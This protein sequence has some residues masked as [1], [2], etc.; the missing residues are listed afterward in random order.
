MGNHVHGRCE[1]VTN[2]M[3]ITL[4][5]VFEALATPISMPKG[6]GRDVEEYKSIDH[7]FLQHAHILVPKVGGKT[8]NPIW[9]QYFLESTIHVQAT[10]F[11][12]EAS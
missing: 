4:I 2:K 7:K 11:L 6:D 12:L 10:Y 5:S 1:F 9:I 3:I 8:C